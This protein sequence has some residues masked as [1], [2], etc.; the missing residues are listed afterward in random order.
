MDEIEIDD[1][2]DKQSGFFSSLVR[3]GG[4]ARERAR[5][6]RVT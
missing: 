5:L 1:D 6:R 3:M 4:R 2:E